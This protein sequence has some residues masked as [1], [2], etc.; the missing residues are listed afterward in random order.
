V[1]SQL[2]GLPLSISGIE[3]YWAGLRLHD[4]V[5]R[6]PGIAPQQLQRVDI[7]PAW[8]SL[9]RG[10]IGV[11]VYFRGRDAQGEIWIASREDRLRLQA[12]DIRLGMRRLLHVPGMLVPGGDIHLSGDVLLDMQTYTPLTGHLGMQWIGATLR[13][14]DQ[15]MH[16]G[17]Y[18]LDVEHKPDGWRWHITGGTAV[19]AEGSG[20]LVPDG[21]LGMWRLEG[22]MV[23]AG[24]ALAD[25]PGM[26]GHRGRMRLRIRGRLMRPSIQLQPRQT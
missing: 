8:R 4:V 26:E 24:P 13:I 16:L 25:M 17:D 22:D 12:V 1:I 20:K 9:L 18:R 7:T 21:R 5:I 3:K 23:L 6:P 15:P 10:A 11:D 19:T 14:G 2:A